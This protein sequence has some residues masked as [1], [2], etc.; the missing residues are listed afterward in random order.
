M[1]S[2]PGQPTIVIQTLP[3]V[4]RSKDNQTMKFGQLKEYNVRNI[5]LEKSCT[6]YGRETRPRPFSGK[7][8]ISI[9]LDRQSK[10]LHSL[11][12]LNPNLLLKYIETTL[13][14]TCFY[15]I[16]SIFKIQRGLEL[17]S[18]CLIFCIIFEGKYFSCYSLLID[19]VSLPSCLVL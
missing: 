17:V 9:S 16:I 4:S 14:T 18:P 12:S 15:L 2:Q 3:N 11:F 5:F 19:Q 10:V 13:Q 7:S 1:T 8:K 6:R